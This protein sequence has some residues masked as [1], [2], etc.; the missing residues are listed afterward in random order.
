MQVTH[1][2]DGAGE[3]LLLVS[4]LG[5]V[6][7]RWRRVVSLLNDT[8][9]VVTFDN[10]ETGGTGPSEDGFALADIATDALD[11]M[12]T[13]G[14]ERFFL[15][16]ISMGGM[17]SQEIIRL[18][19]DRVKAAVLL[20]THRG[21]PHAIPPPDPSVLMPTDDRPIWA[22]LSGPGYAQAHPD[23]I[24]EETQLSVESATLPAGYGR[25]MQAIMSFDPGDAVR[26]S[27]VP[28][29]VAHGDADPLVPYDNGVNLAKHLGVELVT[30]PG[31]GHVLESERATEVA[32]L[33]RRHF[34]AR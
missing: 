1:D 6:G 8:Y 14:H 31:A 34:T 2:V 19:P 20:S 27:G 23:V 16:G 10:R 32:D 25:Q 30:Y 13:L 21:A 33:M 18:A 9:T 4:G 7:R 5:Q 22:K 17:I 26:D 28:I 24:A 11:L 3:A 12:S 29:V 15:G